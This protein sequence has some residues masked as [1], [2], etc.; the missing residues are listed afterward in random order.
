MSKTFPD[1]EELDT[2]GSILLF[3]KGSSTVFSKEGFGSSTAPARS[4]RLAPDRGSIA[5]STK[6]RACHSPAWDVSKNLV[7][8][9]W[10]VQGV[11]NGVFGIEIGD[12]PSV[13]P[14]SEEVGAIVLSDERFCIA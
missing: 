12:L 6:S 1:R 8:G 2:V 9:T 5:I 14:A 10:F 11:S 7:R 13:A 3:L 4:N